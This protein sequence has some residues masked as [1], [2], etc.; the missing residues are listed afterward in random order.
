M[1]LPPALTS[2]SPQLSSAPLGWPLKLTA[3]EDPCSSSPPAER[4]P[5]LP[6]RPGSQGVDPRGRRRRHCPLQQY[7]AIIDHVLTAAPGI[8]TLP[9]EVPSALPV[10]PAQAAAGP[11]A[12]AAAGAAAPL[13]QQGNRHTRHE[14]TVSL[15]DLEHA[16]LRNKSPEED[17]YNLVDAMYE[18]QNPKRPSKEVLE[19]EIAEEQSRVR[20]PHDTLQRLQLSPMIS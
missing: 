3:R 17:R 16:E 5:D 18:I 1:P 10:F 14:H 2:A 8:P 6:Q 13:H 15:G 4:Q 7:P 11:A 12:S 19:Q 9:P 20:R